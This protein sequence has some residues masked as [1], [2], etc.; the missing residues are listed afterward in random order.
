M[1]W[2]FRTDCRKYPQ[3]E[4][5]VNDPNFPIM[6]TMICPI[7]KRLQ[8]KENGEVDTREPKSFFRRFF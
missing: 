6:G 4:F 2:H 5:E 1:E 3:E 8:A 7:C